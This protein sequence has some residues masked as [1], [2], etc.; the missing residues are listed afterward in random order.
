M[1]P[2]LVPLIGPTI[3]FGVELLHSNDHYCFGGSHNN[4][5][6]LWY[7]IPANMFTIVNII[8]W[9]AVLHKVCTVLRSTTEQRISSYP[10]DIQTRAR[11][12]A[13]H[14]LIRAAIILI[15]LFGVHSVIFAIAPTED[16]NIYLYH[17]LGFLQECITPIT[18]I[19][20]A[21]VYCFAN[22]DVQQHIKL[23]VES[24]FSAA[25]Q[26]S[27]KSSFFGRVR[28]SIASRAQVTRF[29]IFF[30]I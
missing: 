19:I 1:V 27:N 22:D 12:N 28:Q 24:F 30:K 7:I 23:C 20:I 2:W 17:F 21:S 8:M 13:H 25:A 14:G 6:N 3:G 10:T 5:T 9:F 11:R 15:P 4:W 29:F 18:G 26:N 16:E